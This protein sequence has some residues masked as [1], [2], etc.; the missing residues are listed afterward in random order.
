MYLTHFLACRDVFLFTFDLRHICASV[1]ASTVR[2]Y[3]PLHLLTYL[4]FYCY[5]VSLSFEWF[6]KVAKLL[7]KT[8]PKRRLGT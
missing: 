8:K 1:C 3:G 6:D 5:F 4:T 2:F 7:G